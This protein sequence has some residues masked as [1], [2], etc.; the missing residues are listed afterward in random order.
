MQMETNGKAKYC[1]RI[2]CTGRIAWPGMRCGGMTWWEM[3]CAGLFDEGR[4]EVRWDDFVTDNEGGCS[5]DR[6]GDVGWS[7]ERCCTVISNEGRLK[8]GMIWWAKFDD[9]GGCGDMGSY[10]ERCAEVRPYDE[11]VVRWDVMMRDGLWRDVVMRG[12]GAMGLLYKYERCGGVGCCGLLWWEA[13]WGGMLPSLKVVLEWFEP[14]SFSLMQYDP[15]TASLVVMKI[16]VILVILVL[17]ATWLLRITTH[18]W[19]K[20]IRSI[21]KYYY[22]NNVVFQL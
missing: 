9:E 1:R 7:G 15:Y 16:R 22:G 21:Q 20:L 3:W 18:F 10:D 6:C 19:K 14:F 8:G 12:Y 2:P 17:V 13:G 11:R 5:D 4:R